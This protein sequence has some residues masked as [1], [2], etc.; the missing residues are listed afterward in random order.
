[1]NTNLLPAN[2]DMSASP[3]LRMASLLMTRFFLS[4]SGVTLSW[5]SVTPNSGAASN[6]LQK[7]ALKIISKIM[8]NIHVNNVTKYS[9]VCTFLSTM[10]SNISKPDFGKNAIF[11]RWPTH[12]NSSLSPKRAYRGVLLKQII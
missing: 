12:R 7:V 4:R 2:S 10:I 5:V 3:C 11:W 8:L 9:Y 1:M 6:N